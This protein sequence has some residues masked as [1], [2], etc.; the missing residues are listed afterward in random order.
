MLHRHARIALTA[1][2]AAGL[3]AGGIAGTASATPHATRAPHAQRLSGPHIL[4][5][6]HKGGVLDLKG[7]KTVNAGAVHFTVRSTHGDW[8]LSAISLKKGYTLKDWKADLTAF[9]QSMN[10]QGQPSKAGLRHLR[11]AINH[12][13]GYG[14]FEAN[15]KTK[16]AE[17]GTLHL[18]RPGTVYIFNSENGLPISLHKLTVKPTG[19][20]TPLPTTA[21]RVIATTKRRFAGSK[22]LPA[23]GTITFKNKSTESPHFLV[24]QH[25]KNGTTRKQVINGLQGNSAPSWARAGE[26]STDILT[27]GQAQTLDTNLPKG[28][29]A[30]MCFFPD[31]QTGM[32]H[33]LM[34]MVGIVHLK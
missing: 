24:L 30:E 15:A 23:K 16:L 10:Q 27:Y 25:V 32:P 4:A 14:G 28:E 9:G 3:I 1:A 5:T 11:R 8:T 12:A 31:P 33:A 19:A 22:I 6:F 2:A 26:E 20:I 7:P 17:S 13:F 34:G 18:T 21:T 29:Y